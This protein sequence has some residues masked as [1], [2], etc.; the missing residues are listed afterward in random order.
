[1]QRERF[2]VLKCLFKQSLYF[3]TFLFLEPIETALLTFMLKELSYWEVTVLSKEN[4]PRKFN[5]LL[6][7]LRAFRFVV[8]GQ[9]AVQQGINCQS[10]GLDQWKRQEILR[11][12]N[13]DLVV[14]FKMDNITI[15]MKYE[16]SS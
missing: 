12:R 7:P 14:T 10:N 4:E 3:Y 16:N 2:Q 9:A 8:S 5:G 6:K 15:S 11:L 1:M 13:V